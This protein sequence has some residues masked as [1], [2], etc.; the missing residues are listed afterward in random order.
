MRRPS[1]FAVWP[2]AAWLGL[3]AASAGWRGQTLPP[4]AAQLNRT[5]DHAASAATAVRLYVQSLKLAPDNGP[6]LYG[7][8]RALLDLDRARESFAVFRRLDALF[9][10]DPF[11]L[12][13]LATASACRPG[14][15]RADVAE[16]LGF[17]ERATRLRPDAPETWHALSV[18]RHLDG[19]YA[20][21]AEAARQAVA[22]DARQPVDPETT[23][24]YQ[25]QETACHDA[26]SV[27]SPLD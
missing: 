5:A 24:R 11:V 12:E 25:Q 20:A 19:D 8:G 17:A 3:A 23:A 18:L 6:A 9:P 14:L 21:A 15:R 4:E 2:L 16:G 13:A 1:S 22:L 7:L 27:F 26:L 10:D